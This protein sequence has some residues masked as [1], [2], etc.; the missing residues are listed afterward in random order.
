V[1][2]AAVWIH[3]V[4]AFI[5]MGMIIILAVELLII[6]RFMKITDIEV[7]KYTPLFTPPLTKPWRESWH[8]DTI[9][10]SRPLV[11]YRG[12]R[13]NFKTSMPWYDVWVR[14]RGESGL[15]GFGATQFGG[16]VVILIRDHLAPNLIGEDL[17]DTERLADLM[18]RLTKP[19]GSAGIASCAAS[20]ID[21]ALWDLKGRIMKQPVYQLLS[22]EPTDIPCYAS[23]NDVDWAVELGFDAVKITLGYGAEAGSE[24]L[25]RNE[26][27]IATCRETIGDQRELYVDCWMSLDVEYSIQLA[28]RLRPYRIGWLEECLL[29]EDLAGHVELRKKL[30]ELTLTGGEH[31]YSHFM[32]EWA[33]K[34]KVVSILQPDIQWCGGLSAVLEVA[35]IAEASGVELLP[36]LS[37]RT[38]FGQHVSVGISAIQRAEY[39]ITTAPGIPLGEGPQFPGKVLPSVGRMS[40][41]DAYGFGVEIPDQNLTPYLN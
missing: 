17:L 12:R 15:C 30:P 10:I 24:G 38:C 16:P 18:F 40:A 5:N 27:F 11:R 19:Y 31:W 7:L 39:L 25:V 29:P 9:D 2:N 6:C 14:I 37:A 13:V 35:T 21:L 33:A 36:H 22:G 8:D 41:S 20:A 28:E 3:A 26:E 23:S 34:Q 32:F 1:S 4:I